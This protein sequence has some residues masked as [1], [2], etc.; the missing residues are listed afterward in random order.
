MSLDNERI[1]IAQG[2]GRIGLKEYRQAEELFRSVLRENSACAEAFFELGKICYIEARHRQAAEYLEK[3]ISLNMADYYA[4]L[5][6]GKVYKELKDYTRAVAAFRKTLSLGYKEKEVYQELFD[7]CKMQEFFDISEEEL[8]VACTL[9]YGRDVCRLVQGYNLNGKYE[10]TARIVP[11][12][13]KVFPEEELLL[14]NILLN[15][16]EIAQKKDVLVSYPRR[17]TVTLSNRCNLSCIMCLT[18]KVKWEIPRHVLEEIYMLFPYMEKVMWQGGEVFALPFF[19]E[20][21]TRG[22]AYPHLRH[23]IVTNAQLISEPMAHKL[24][25]NNVELTISIDGFTKQVYEYIRKGGSFEVLMKNIKLIAELKRSVQSP[26]VL[27]LNM[28]VMKS[29]YRQLE[30]VIDFAHEYGFDFVCLMPI[31]IHLATPEDIFTNRD[32]E[33][34]AF[35]DRVSPAIAEQARQKGVRLE[36]RLFFTK[37]E[38]KP[39]QGCERS[40]PQSAI[41][42]QKKLLCHIPWQ[43][44][45]VDY[46]GTVR[47]DCLCLIEHQAGSLVSG[48]SLWGIW[49][50]PVMQEYRHKIAS[51]Q[52][53]GYCNCLCGSGAICESHL[54][55]P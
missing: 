11:E 31:H 41:P 5:L 25:R 34:L 38:E 53:Q 16:L 28:A 6:L 46:N 32:A 24:V 7:S 33:A 1:L 39:V 47:P 18:S 48:D 12:I 14:R 54:K 52:H 10:L 29:N 36:N 50:N 37:E 42:A 15:E 22:F 19:E 21:L 3:A 27:N 2:R 4:Y 23:S 13:I 49:N 26:M 55:I 40:Q 44:L 30:R 20:V 8:R 9:G 35:I 17:L 43:Q 45:L 51:G